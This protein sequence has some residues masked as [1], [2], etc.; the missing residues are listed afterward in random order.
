MSDKVFFSI[1]LPTY[2]REHK[3]IN[4]INSVINQTFE[5][6]EL[7]IIDNKSTD[8]TKEIVKRFKNPKIF[9]Y[10]ID[11]KGIIAKSRN[12][13]IYKSNGNYLCFLDSDDWWHKDKLRFVYEETLNGSSFIY[14]NHYVVK[15]NYLL[16]KKNYSRDLITPVFEDL[17][18]NGLH[19]ATSSVVV[20][21]KKFLQ[22]G[23]FD[24]GNEF[25][26]WEDY[27]A[28]LKFS[29]LN[30][31]FAFLNKFLSYITIDNEN[32]LTNE[33]KIE[34]IN[35]FSKKYILDQNINLPEWCYIEL[36][37]SLYCLNRYNDALVYLKKIN[38]KNLNYLQKAKMIIFFSLIKIKLKLK[39]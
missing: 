12:Y 30:F 22:I 2:N 11:N 1:I 25:I 9:F 38:Y 4:A 10:D 16:K 14:H 37:K 21:K 18:N 15:S 8:N 17:I 29:K 33:K 26:S 32:S 3:I 7:I 20:E 39:M 36:I 6:W 35:M 28:W 31:N 24:E 19:F 34:N 23:C 5:N 13:G 27:D